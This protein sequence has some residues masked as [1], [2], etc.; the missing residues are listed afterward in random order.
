[1]SGDG[2]AA[3]MR[4][5]SW[6]AARREQVAQRLM[7]YIAID[8]VTPRE[9]A[10]EGFLQ[11]Y[12]ASVGA[13]LE[14]LPFPPDIAEHW[15]FSPHVSSR[16]TTDRGSWRSLLGAGEGVHPP[17]TLF[18]AHVD[19]VPASPDFPQAFSPVRVDDRI[20]GRGACDTKNN[21]VMVVEA[22]RFLREEGIP[23]TRTVLLDLPI[24]EEIG[25]NG[26]LSQVLHAPDADEAICLE[27]TSLEVLRGHRGCLTFRVDVY[28]RSV[29]MGSSATGMDAIAG[30]IDVIGKLRAL[31]RELL[32]QAADE[33]GFEHVGTPLQLNVGMISGG[34]WSGSVPERCTVLADF[35]FLPSMSLSDMESRIEQA[36]RSISSAWMS[37]RLS[38]RFD[39]G[40]RNDAYM[41]PTD[42]R[43][44]AELGAAAARYLAQRHPI[45]GWRVS[46]D[47]RLY[48]KVGGL[49][50]AVFGSGSLVNAHSPHEEVSLTEVGTGAAILADF[51]STP[52]APT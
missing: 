23:L 37:E 17:R 18:N 7:D 25:G 33:P 44:I 24:E 10:A 14:F 22:V 4:F 27:P 9:S 29:H 35:G 45:G 8:T 48:Q 5:P 26:T 3:R 47:A 13:K 40:L 11:E 50:T 49:P 6:F 30:A 28:G 15:S 34:E 39:V 43:V 38:V 20:I 21:L 2:T 46:C 52:S 36:C 32:S 12:L 51:L 42:A 16:S 1:M 41:S 19:V 31:E